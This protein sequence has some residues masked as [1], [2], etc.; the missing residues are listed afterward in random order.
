[1]SKVLITQSLLTDFLVKEKQVG[2]KRLR[3]LKVMLITPALAL[4]DRAYKF[5]KYALAD[6]LTNMNLPIM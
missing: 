5:K 6:T 4:L 2:R 1:M 3:W